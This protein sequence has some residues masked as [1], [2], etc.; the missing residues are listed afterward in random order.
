MTTAISSDLAIVTLADCPTATER[1]LVN[2]GRGAPVTQVRTAL[3]DGMRAEVVAVVQEITGRQVVAYL[4]AHQHDPDLAVIA[5][6]LAPSAGLDE[7][8]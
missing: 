5:F 4:T 8:R 1:T 2:E 3:H 7:D 6:Q